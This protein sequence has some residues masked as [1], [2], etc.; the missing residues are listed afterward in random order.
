MLEKAGYRY[1]VIGGLALSQWGIVH[2][3]YDI[4]IK[5]L[6]PDLDYTKIRSLLSSTFRQ[7]ARQKAFQK[8]AT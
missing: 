1:A 4:D 6:V 2:A 3:T 7:S 8:L 5:V